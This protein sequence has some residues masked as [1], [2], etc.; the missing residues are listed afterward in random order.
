MMYNLFYEDIFS[1]THK[2][3]AL[4]MVANSQLGV[5]LTN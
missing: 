4:G 2:V 5:Y 3:G 1:V